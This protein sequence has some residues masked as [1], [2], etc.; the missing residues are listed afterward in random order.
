MR[1]G[2]LIVG[3]EPGGLILR[4]SPAGEGFVLY[5]APKREITAVA[6]AA[7]GTIYATG[8]GNKGGVGAGLP[9]TFNVIAPQPLPSTQPGSAPQ[10][11]APK[12][13]AVTTPLPTS[14]REAQVSGGSELYRIEKDDYPRRVWSQPQDIAYAIGFDAQGR[15]IV[16]TGNK[17]NI[18]RIDAD[19]LS[20]L[21]INASPTQ[22][23]SLASGPRSALYAATGNIGRVY[24]IGPGLEQQGTFESDPLDVGSFSYWGRLSDIAD[25]N[26]GTLGF[27]T[28]SGN[29]DRP[30]NNWS[31]WAPIDL[32]KNSRVTSP[33]ARFLQYRLTMKAAADGKSPEAPFGGGGLPDQ[34]R[35]A[36]D[37]R[38]RSD[39]AQLQVP[40]SDADADPVADHH[41]RAPGAAPPQA[42]ADLHGI[43]RPQP[44]D[45]VRQGP[46]RRAL[47]RLGRERRRPHLHGRDQ[48]H[49]GD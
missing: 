20:T 38:D 22:V 33:S 5:Q 3:T 42:R 19:N 31:P 25:S 35:G 49:P 17:G 37:R 9:P 44:G 29:L 43:G 34:E 26:G 6:V 13:T 21:L 1:T 11:A 39:A 2:N 36:D 14:G 47:G 24:Q 41:A 8:V 7:D 23:T 18:Y 10:T 27:E 16:G 48:G 45:D 46:D 4:V 28:R 15:P 32:A 12:P 30:A 40:D